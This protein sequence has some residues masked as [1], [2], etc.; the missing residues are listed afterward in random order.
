MPTYL[1]AHAKIRKLIFEV[2][3]PG[4]WFE[5]DII[6]NDFSSSTIGDIQIL[7]F[8]TGTEIPKKNGI[9]PNDSST[10]TYVVNHPPAP[11]TNNKTGHNVNKI[12][13]V[14]I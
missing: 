13:T 7:V 6:G 2:Q 4:N 1:N 5:F 14:S 8:F 9:Q 11:N 3:F 10:S 12:F